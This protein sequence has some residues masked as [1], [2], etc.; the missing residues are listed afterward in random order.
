[1]VKSMFQT[2]ARQKVGLR[3]VPKALLRSF[4][5]LCTE[6]C[7]MQHSTQFLGCKQWAMST[8][9]MTLD[10]RRWSL[11]PV[12]EGLLCAILRIVVVNSQKRAVDLVRIRS[13]LIKM[14]LSLISYKFLICDTHRQLLWW[15]IAVGNFRSTKQ[16][17]LTIVPLL[18]SCWQHN[19]HVLWTKPL[20]NVTFILASFWSKW[21]SF[22][23]NSKGPQLL[24]QIR[25]TDRSCWTAKSDWFVTN[26]C[27]CFWG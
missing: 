2:Q 10:E 7:A 16:K 27:N 24:V 6:R 20:S 8:I 12:G 14:C 5:K 9:P 15:N 4:V 11:G 13:F 21:F 1:M 19:E 25:Q 3:H 26:C 23:N 17:L 18:T 22:A